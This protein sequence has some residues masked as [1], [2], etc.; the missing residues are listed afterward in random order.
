[1]IVLKSIIQ[2]KPIR[3]GL[4]V[5]WIGIILWVFIPHLIHHTPKLVDKKLI[6]DC[7]KLGNTYKIKITS[8]GFDP[9][10]IQAKR[11]DVVEIIN[12]DSSFHEP[13]FGPHPIHLV[14]PGYTEKLLAPKETNKFI[15][16]AYGQYEMHDHLN[17]DLN[18]YLNISN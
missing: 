1:M 17:E 16:K 18:T 13:A 5:L 6:S 9:Q 3:I 7:Q 10:E 12:L 4:F 8:R 11:C 14:Y 2:R 15:L